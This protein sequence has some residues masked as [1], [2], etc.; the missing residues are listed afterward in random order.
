MIHCPGCGGALRF[1][2]PSQQMIC[3]M[4]GAQHDPAITASINKEAKGTQVFEAYSYLCPS[5]GGELL[6]TDKTDAIGFCP[7]CGGASMLF[8]RIHEQWEP[9]FVI[10]FQI[11]KEQCKELYVKHAKRTIFSS[12]KYRDPQLIDGFRGIYMPYYCYQAVQQGRFSMEGK[13]K[14][15]FTT[16][17][18]RVT[19]DTDVRLDGYAHDAA[20]DFSDRMSENIA[21]F[22]PAGHKPFVPGYLSGFYADVGDVD[23]ESYRAAGEQCMKASTAGIMAEEP[24]VTRG[25]GGMHKLKINKKSA[26]IPTKIISSERVLYPVWFMSYRNKDRITYAAVNGQTGRV[27]A[28]L[29][30][31]PWKIL[32]AVL[33]LGAAL[34]AAMFVLPSI[35]ANTTLILTE[36]LLAI[37]TIILHS[38]YSRAIAPRTGLGET[39][40][41]QRFKK[42]NKWRYLLV[43]ITVALGLFIAFLDPAYNAISYG[44][45]ILT[46]FELFYLMCCHIRFQAEIAKREPPQFQ[47]KGA[48]N[49]E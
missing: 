32:I 3:E 24:S 49:D 40:E 41:A 18:Y 43:V 25:A 27:T 2:I 34:A 11:T 6:T 9:S 4:C 5:C 30:L 23:P 45:C 47:K 22:D 28:D 21:P 26:S 48:A 37:G 35:K 29:P 33:L 16:S 19:G 31:S 36:I 14:G 1:D 20:K 8:D 13:T 38:S 10:P 7:F 44:M 17:T 46:S 39:Q 42:R 15:V 12:G